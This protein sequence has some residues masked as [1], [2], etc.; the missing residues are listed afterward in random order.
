MIHP[1]TKYEY[2]QKF[3]WQAPIMERIPRAFPDDKKEGHYLD[4]FNTPTTNANG[5]PREIHDFLPRARVKK[6]FSLGKLSSA[7]KQTLK[8]LSKKL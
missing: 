4:V 3:H 6:L 2:C 7:D 1:D 8:D 5:S